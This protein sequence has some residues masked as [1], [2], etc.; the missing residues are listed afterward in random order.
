MD[1]MDKKTVEQAFDL[2]GLEM[3][4]QD[5]VAEMAVFG[6]SAIM[7]ASNLRASTGDVDAIFLN[8]AALLTQ[9]ADKVGDRL[10]LPHD[11][12]NQAVRRTVEAGSSDLGDVVDLFDEYPRSDKSKVGLRVFVA[13]PVYMLAMK[14]LANRGEFEEDKAQSDIEDI[15]G[16]MRVTGKDTEE[17]LVSVLR[18]CYSHIPGIVKPHLALRIKWK[19]VEVLD[20]YNAE[21][22]DPTW[23]P[24]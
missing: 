13:N 2:V 21:D 15:R 9:A 20:G 7:L 22:Y 23:K 8:A 6:G 24:R 10:G 5:I 19:I 12:L 16:L 17:Q 14:L 4:R 1:R 18:S 11:W 3:A